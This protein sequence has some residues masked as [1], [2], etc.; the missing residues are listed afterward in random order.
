MF[1]SEFTE[2]K[3]FVLVIALFSVKISA[4]VYWYVSQLYV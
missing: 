3:M 4:V 2:E 1:L